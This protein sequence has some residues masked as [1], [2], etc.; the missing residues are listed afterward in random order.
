VP[1]S[2]ELPNLT[3]DRFPTRT[4]VQIETDEYLDRPESDGTTPVGGRK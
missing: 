1:E 2:E 3:F 4:H